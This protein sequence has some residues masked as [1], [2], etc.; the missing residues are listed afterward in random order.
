MRMGSPEP[1][2]PIQIAL[3]VVSLL[4]LGGGLVIVFKGSGSI[5]LSNMALLSTS[6]VIGL[7]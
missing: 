5:D 4:P 3:G 6:V 7:L 1:I 2:S